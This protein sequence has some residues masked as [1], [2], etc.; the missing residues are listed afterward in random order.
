M[1]RGLSDSITALDAAQ[2]VQ[3]LLASP[4]FT[5]F[6]V[7]CP[8]SIEQG[9]DNGLIVCQAKFDCNIHTTYEPVPPAPEPTVFGVTT[10]QALGFTV[11]ED[12]VI[13]TNL[14]AGDLVLPGTTLGSNLQYALAHN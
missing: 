2:R 5:T 8:K 1:N 7:M 11:D 3:E 4:R 14:P 9:E 12:G 13:T 10:Q 6:G